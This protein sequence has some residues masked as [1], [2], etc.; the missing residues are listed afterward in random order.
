MIQLPAASSTCALKTFSYLFIRRPAKQVPKGPRT[1]TMLIYV[2]L[3]FTWWGMSFFP[4]TPDMM[5]SHRLR[6]F[7][8]PL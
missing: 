3:Y 1:Y 4:F 8:A 2:D 6:C 5:V 7:S